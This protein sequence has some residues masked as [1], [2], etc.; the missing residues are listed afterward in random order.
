MIIVLLNSTD[1]GI[2]WLDKYSRCPF[3]NKTVTDIAIAPDDENGFIWPPLR[4]FG[5]LM[6]KTGFIRIVMMVLTTI[7]LDY[8]T[9]NVS[10]WILTNQILSMLVEGHQVSDNLMGFIFLKIGGKLGKIYQTI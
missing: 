1:G 10:L 9:F 3:P 7:F 6:G 2:T 8:V 4:V 5:I